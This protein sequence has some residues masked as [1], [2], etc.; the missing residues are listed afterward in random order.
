MILVEALHL[1]GKN[2]KIKLFAILCILSTLV[3]ASIEDEYTI[4]FNENTDGAD[5]YNLFYNDGA[6]TKPLAE[7]IPSD[8]K[9]IDTVTKPPFKFTPASAP[10]KLD[11]H[12]ACF[13]MT[14]FNSYG[15]SVLSDQVCDK[16]VAPGAPKKPLLKS[17]DFQVVR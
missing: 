7:Q 16:E 8:L 12:V 2:M 9:P 17:E 10:L 4:N 11:K 1:Q 5:G 6:V 3:G 13:R 15:E 14:A